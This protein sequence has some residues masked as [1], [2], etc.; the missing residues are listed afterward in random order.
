MKEARSRLIQPLKYKWLFKRRKFWFFW[1]K[2]LHQALFSRQC[3]LLLSSSIRKWL[4][5]TFHPQKYMMA[6]DK[7]KSHHKH[8][9]PQI[10]ISNMK[11]KW[12]L[13]H[14][15][16][17]KCAEVVRSSQK[18]TKANTSQIVLDSS[19]PVVVTLN[20]SWSF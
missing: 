19:F 10:S 13:S 12:N 18:G 17:I 2:C 7:P 15:F 6:E 4:L 1:M 14:F 5:L 9:F 3:C 11:K 8:R 16:S 20:K